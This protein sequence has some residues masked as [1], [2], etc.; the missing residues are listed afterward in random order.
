MN[1]FDRFIRQKVK[2]EQ[3]EIP[4]SV[5]VS[6][7]K[8]LSSLPETTPKANKIHVFPKIAAAAAC[9]L[10]VC[11]V[12]LPNCS[13]LY[14]QALEKIPVIGGIVKVVSIR[15]Y[16]YADDYHEMDIEVPKIESE[17]NDA[18]DAINKEVDELTRILAERFDKDFQEIGD[19]GHSAVYAD[20]AVVTN[21]EE[22]F[23]LKIRV[24]EV[25]GSGNI[26]Y[27]YYHIDKTN[28]KIVTLGDLSAD[29]NFYTVLENEIRRQMREIMAT[30]SEKTYWVDDALLG[31]DFVKLDGTH[32]FYW[33]ESGDLV[34]VFDKYEV[35]PGYMGTPE[36]AI[37]KEVIQDV[38]LPAY[39]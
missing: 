32:N 25:A 27:K 8:T 13:V 28:G 38:L 37:R 12:V 30:D 34:I 18:V 22:W 9:F 1:E 23:T 7:E 14:A 5:L 33:S 10:V 31:E 17:N 39:D 26:Y 36:F 16:F 15:N 29:E 2:E 19:N 6:V 24:H 3:T 4:H 11:L 35:A 21:T 20:Y